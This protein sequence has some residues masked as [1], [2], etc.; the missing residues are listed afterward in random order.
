M[1]KHSPGPW[2]RSSLAPMTVY[3]A[4]GEFVATV[5]REEDVPVVIAAPTLL[6]EV[7]RLRRDRDIL[8]TRYKVA[9]EIIGSECHPD[10]DDQREAEEFIRTFEED[11]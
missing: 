2:E 5:G 11:S 6:A 4:T 3:D 7:E 8:L 1:S 10:E 9:V